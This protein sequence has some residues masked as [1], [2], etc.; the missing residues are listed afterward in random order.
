MVEE[1]G[2][3]I[4]IPDTTQHNRSFALAGSF[5]PRHMNTLLAPC[6][7][8]GLCH[9]LNERRARAHQILHT[10][11]S[12]YWISER[13]E[14]KLPLLM[15]WTIRITRYHPVCATTL[16]SALLFLLHLRGRQAQPVG[17]AEEKHPAVLALGAFIGLNPLAP[18]CALVECP[19]ESN[20][21]TLDIA[22]VVLAHDGLDSLGGFVGV[23]EGDS[24]D[25]VVQDVSL[26]DAVEEVTTDE[27]E[28]AVNGCGGATSEV[29]RATSVVRE[30]GVGVLEV[31]D[32]DK[33][34]VHPEVRE[35]VPHSQ[36]PPAEVLAD[37]CE[38]AASDQ[39]TQVRQQNQLLVLALIKRRAG[40][41]M[42]HASIAILAALTFALSLTLML[43]VARNVAQQ[44]PRPAD[45]LLANEHGSGVQWRLFH[46]LMHL[47]QDVAH[48][49]RVLLARAR[50]EDH[51]TLHVASGLVVLSMAD[52]PAE[53][54]DQKSGVREPANG[55]VEG[56][57]RR[58]GLMTAL[59]RQ[60]PE[61][62][63]EEAL[64][65]GVASPQSSAEGIRR[66]VG[67]CAVGVEEVEG[68][69]HKC[70]IASDVAQAT[71]T[72]PLKAMLGD[73]IADVLDRVVW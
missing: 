15:C 9:N 35:D 68:A 29:P 31:G 54:W 61:A 52:L 69:C 24:G 33:P 3:P 51:V 13:R 10:S 2:E 71:K 64:K 41:E 23:V 1:R 17:V 55:V 38:N 34:V 49:A 6:P 40:Q 73:S 5:T 22:S 44:V 46:K 14:T 50:Q 62:G 8:T 39:E 53:V 20:W 7:D 58:E 30:R 72:R 45:Q 67:R 65:E 63:A 16:S 57:G 42:V 18:S 21:S 27:A 47:M 25:V 37:E 60:Y 48:S 66:H 70:Y 32:S 12:P 26:D 19:D 28:F 56:L 11:S 36:I 4:S 59:V 43:V